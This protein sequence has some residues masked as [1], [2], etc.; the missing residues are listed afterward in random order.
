[1]TGSVENVICEITG[2]PDMVRYFK[3]ER[4][5]IIEI[6]VFLCLENTCED[7]RNNLLSLS[8]MK[9]RGSSI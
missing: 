1:M 2:D 4:E 8:M 9:L 3:K 5:Y 7:R 6:E